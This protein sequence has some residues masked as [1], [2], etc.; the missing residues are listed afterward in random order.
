MRLRVFIPVAAT[1]LSGC[2]V[3]PP[4]TPRMLASAGGVSERVLNEGRELYGGRCTHCHAPDPIW[5]YSIPR[6]REIT[7]DMAPRSKLRPEQKAA[8]LAY[9]E[10]AHKMPQGTAR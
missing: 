7:E 3:A 8:L 6:W 5:K 4:V 9:L 10:A 2:V 1:L